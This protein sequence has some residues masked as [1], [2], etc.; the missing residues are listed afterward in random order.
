MNLNK[1]YYDNEGN[2]KNILQMVK[3]EP[4]WA[5]NRIQVGEQLEQKNADMQKTLDT[6]F[7]ANQKLTGEI[8]E[9]KMKIGLYEDNIIKGSEKLLQLEQKN[10]ILKDDKRVFINECN[11]L[12]IKKIKLEQEKAELIELIKKIKNGNNILQAGVSIKCYDIIQK[13]TEEN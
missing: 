7:N 11:E 12:R 2:A 6:Q 4:E 3:Y 5:A 9:L 1:V 8:A 13:Y 10:E